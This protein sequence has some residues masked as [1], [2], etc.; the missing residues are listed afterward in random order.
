MAGEQGK[1]PSLS[2]ELGVKTVEVADK[3]GKVWICPPLDLED[4]ADLESSG[5]G[6]VT[7]WLW[8]GFSIKVMRAI[9][10]ASLRKAGKTPQ[11]IADRKFTLKIPD[12]GMMFNAAFANKI[13]AVAMEILENSGFSMQKKG[14][15]DP[16][17]EG[18][19]TSSSGDASSEPPM[20]QD[21]ARKP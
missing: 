4:I 6:P 1:E 20:P 21:T 7:G 11:E 17:A 16:K 2:A 10:W 14:A 18:G 5:L 19:P 9:L 13:G 8:T 15:G 12:V 3:S